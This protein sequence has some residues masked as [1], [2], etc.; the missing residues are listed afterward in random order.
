MWN[1]CIAYT[2]IFVNIIYLPQKKTTTMMHKIIEKQDF[3]AYVKHFSKKIKN[4][5]M[6][7]FRLE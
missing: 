4:R 6:D 2:L 3:T 1:I 5:H 7:F